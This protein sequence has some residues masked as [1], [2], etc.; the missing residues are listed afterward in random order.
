M[1]AAS[2]GAKDTRGEEIGHGFAKRVTF[3]VGKD[4]KVISTIGGVKPNENVEQALA[5]VEKLGKAPAGR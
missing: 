2:P 5:E 1:A 4:G 3:I